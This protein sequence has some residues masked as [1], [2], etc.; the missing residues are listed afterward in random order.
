MEGQ[1]AKR[2]GGRLRTAE[3]TAALLGTAGAST[4]RGAPATKR[5]RPRSPSSGSSSES[6]GSGRRK[7]K[8]KVAAGTGGAT[9]SPDVAEALNK[10]RHFVE[11]AG[12]EGR[13]RVATGEAVA[14]LPVE[15]RSLVQ[16]ALTSDKENGKS[17]HPTVRAVGSCRR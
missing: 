7:S 3:E 17:E 15:L 11:K 14:S 10:A 9:I 16:R 12:G 4:A 6:S 13:G 2:H 1:A 8:R 5:R